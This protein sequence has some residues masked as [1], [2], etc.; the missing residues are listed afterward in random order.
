[1]EKRIRVA[2]VGLGPIGLKVTQFLAERSGL[3]LVA[4]IDTDPKKAG[5]DLGELAGLP[6]RLEIRVAGSIAE[7]LTGKQV[8]AVL[9]TTTSS[10]EKTWPQLQELLP[11]GVNV[12]SSCEEMSYPWLTNPELARKIDKLAQENG[13]SVLS[14][15][16]NP[17]Y[18]MDFL[19][20]A[21]TGIC[22]TVTKVTVERFQNA[23][24]RRV[25]FQRKIGAGL[26]VTEFDNKVQEG[27][28]RHVGL[29]E[30]V[31]LIAHKLGWHL[32]KT[33]DEIS[34]II[35]EQAVNAGELTIPAGGVLGVQQIGRGFMNKQ[36]MIT[37]IFRAAIGQEDVRDR[38]V[39]QGTPD[40]ELSFKGG[41]NGD[42]GTSAILVNAIPTVV[43][44]RP[45]L[46]TMA[47][48]ELISWYQ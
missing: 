22:R 3:E 47:D 48:I 33:V 2:Q 30:S 1:M 9:L 38:I 23:A 15:G 10:L 11:Y 45:G 29:S 42:V 14:T 27:T 31:Q 32:D 28:L 16:I 40:M 7:G 12:I 18:L 17:G 26:T 13:V 24:F 35:A 8:D 37:L 46:R 25:P 6:E 36:E 20:A 4:A 44:A 5:H 34:P 41:V 39:L 43:S 19:P 21:A